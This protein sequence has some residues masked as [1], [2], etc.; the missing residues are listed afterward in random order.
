MATLVIFTYM[1]QAR[2]VM[3]KNEVP[4]LQRSSISDCPL[5]VLCMH[6]ALLL[7]TACGLCRPTVHH[8]LF[9][10]AYAI[11]Y[12]FEFRS[13]ESFHGIHNVVYLGV[14]RA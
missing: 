5:T 14:V 9:Y 6:L 7:C 13:I 8:Y 4:L 12:R 3:D 11:L 2:H 10:Q 1:Q